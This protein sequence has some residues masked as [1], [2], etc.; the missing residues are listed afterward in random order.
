VTQYWFRPKRF[1]YGATPIT[2]QG[3]AVT[4]ATVLAMVAV[5]SGLPLVGRHHWT[6]PAMLAARFSFRRLSPQDRGRMAVALGWA[7]STQ[8]RSLELVSDAVA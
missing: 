1:G 2:W 5:N 7:V 6:L 3:W 8:F 4:I